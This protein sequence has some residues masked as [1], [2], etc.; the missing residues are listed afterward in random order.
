MLKPS[1]G[2]QPA[3]EFPIASLQMQ[4]HIRGH[5]KVTAYPISRLGLPRLCDGAGHRVLAGSRWSR[6]L[7]RASSVCCR[8]RR[9]VKPRAVEASPAK[10]VVL[11]AGW[12]WAVMQ[13]PAK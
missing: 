8:L 7:E 1:P 12:S 10:A 3:H 4:R 13:P 11:P 2:E 5:P 9:V 6:L